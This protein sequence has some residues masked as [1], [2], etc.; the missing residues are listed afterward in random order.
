MLSA[1]ES[2]CMAS[3]RSASSL[4]LIAAKP[5]STLVRN[6]N[7]ASSRL[8]RAADKASIFVCIVATLSPTSSWTLLCAS[9]VSPCF[10]S[11][12]ASLS[13]TSFCFPKLC[14][15]C[16]CTALSA[17][18][19]LSSCWDFKAS[20]SAWRA[21]C[22]AVTSRSS[23]SSLLRSSAAAL[24][25]SFAAASASEAFSWSSRTISTSVRTPACKLASSLTLSCDSA[26]FLSSAPSC[27]CNCAS[28]EE[29]R[30]ISACKRSL[31]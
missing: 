30:V 24:L 23:S 29:A 27:S 26:S 9:M 25:S 6:F 10:C 20:N 8:P 22:F 14:S 11:I 1:A 31:S 21:H 5:P 12:A 3:H 19:A 28:T 18:T 17:S 2:S 4:T 15:S 7:S 16:S 13:S